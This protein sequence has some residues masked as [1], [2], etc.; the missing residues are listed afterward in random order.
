MTDNT[1]VTY[2]IDGKEQFPG[3]IGKTEFDST[4]AWPVPP[5]APEGA[6]NVL[7]Y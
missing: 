3:T 4:T 1:F 7:F 5:T 6:P 2:A